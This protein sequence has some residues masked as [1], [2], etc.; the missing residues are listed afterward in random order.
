MR[1]QKK[2]KVTGPLADL[3]ANG[4]KKDAGASID[5][6]DFA[7]ARAVIVVGKKALKV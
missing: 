2:V 3:F 7:E 1:G 4:F 6:E 5:T